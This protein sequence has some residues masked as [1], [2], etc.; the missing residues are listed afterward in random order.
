MFHSAGGVFAAMLNIYQTAEVA[1]T[2]PVPIYLRCTAAVCT[3]S[4][5]VLAGGRLMSLTGKSLADLPHTHSWVCMCGSHP[6]D[7]N[8]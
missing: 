7:N 2:F 8:V 4:G 6:V 1:T 3:S 5:V